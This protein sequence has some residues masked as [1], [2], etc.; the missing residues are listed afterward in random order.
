M[1]IT[2]GI[3]LVT[4]VLVSTVLSGN[5]LAAPSWICSINDG[6]QC[7]AQGTTGPPDLGGLTAPTFM[8]VDADSKQVTLLA[9]PDRSGEITPIDVVRRGDGIWVLSGVEAGRAWSMVISDKGDMTLSVTADGST[10]S[11]FGHAMVED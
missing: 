9:P 10:W 11:V 6:V 2:T 3:V 8:R 4:A 1:K 7:D 5:A